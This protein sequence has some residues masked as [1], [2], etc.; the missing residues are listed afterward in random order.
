MG[1][2]NHD[3]HHNNDDFNDDHHHNNHD[4]GHHQNLPGCHLMVNGVCEICHRGMCVQGSRCVSGGFGCRTCD[5]G[6]CTRCRSRHYSTP[7][8]TAGH[9]NCHEC[10][11]NCR[12]CDEGGCTKCDSGHLKRLIS[13]QDSPKSY[14]EC[15]PCPPTCEECDEEGC[16]ECEDKEF[17]SPVIP[18]Q[19]T[20]SLGGGQIECKSCGKECYDCGASGCSNCSPGHFLSPTTANSTKRYFLCEKCI[21]KWC[22]DCDAGGCIKC[23]YGYSEKKLEDKTSQ[24]DKVYV[25][26]VPKCGDNCRKCTDRGICVECDMFYSLIIDSCDGMIF[27]ICL[28]W[29]LVLCLCFLCCCIRVIIKA[30]KREERK[31]KKSEEEGETK[32]RVSGGHQHPQP[33]DST[34]IETMKA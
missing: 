6:G 7:V 24:N 12:Y 2:D 5:S 1:F 19:N 21:Q 9:I 13:A 25:Q 16:T 14:F 3:D 8:A 4:D 20:S 23:K 27:Y 33:M 18:S 29:I 17:L 34:K 22:R 11:K 30:K 26:C 31:P 28:I 10:P 32:N 15:L